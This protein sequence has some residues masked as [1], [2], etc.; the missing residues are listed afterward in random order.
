MTTYIL[1]DPVKVDK[2]LPVFIQKKLEN[3]LFFFSLLKGF[4]EN[5][6]ITKK[7]FPENEK[8]RDFGIRCVGETFKK[9]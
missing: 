9:D 1:H 3:E 7:M 8:D 6:N 4:E 5:Q 2:D